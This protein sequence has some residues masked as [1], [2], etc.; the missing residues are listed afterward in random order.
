TPDSRAP[1]DAPWSPFDPATAW[2]SGDSMTK[3][4]PPAIARDSV[5][6]GSL[7]TFDPRTVTSYRPGPA[8]LV[9]AGQTDT[10]PPSSGPGPGEPCASAR[11]GSDRPLEPE[12]LAGGSATWPRRHRPGGWRS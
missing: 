3:P 12:N 8:R 6:L 11:P 7:V 9:G 2:F 5:P 10:E 1:P 4:S